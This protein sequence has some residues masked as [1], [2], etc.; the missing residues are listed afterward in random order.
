MSFLQIRNLH[1]D[2]G[3][4]RLKGVDLDLEK[5]KYLNIVGPTGAG[6]TILLECLVGFY[7]PDKGNILLEGEEITHKR[8][9][10]RNIGIVYQDYALM[11]HMD[12]YKN[13]AYG[14]HKKKIQDIPARVHEMAE[15]LSITHL[16]HRKPQTLS[17]GEQ[18]RVALARSLA[19]RPRLLLMDEPLSALDPTTKK[20]IRKMLRKVVFQVGTTVIHVTH[21]LDD[22]WTLADEAA[23]MREGLLEQKGT[24]TEV[25]ERPMTD[26]V[27]DFVGGTVLD[28]TLIK[29]E[30]GLSTVNVSG[31]ELKSYDQGETGENVRVIIRPENI[32]LAHSVPDKVSARNVLSCE[33]KEIEPENGL[34]IVRLISNGLE[35]QVLITNNGLHDLDLKKG[36]KV[37]AMIKCVHVRLA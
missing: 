8:P 16:L 1:K 3:E 18:Q 4:F 14:L 21:D 33:I 6:K 15:S 30:N 35:L 9:E 10:K 7:S 34:N 5:G 20:S 28:G 29:R 27:A 11:P 25:L 24:I 13:I 36:D 31:I 22:V 23:V 26:F 32:I 37:F 12:V 19:V 17:G 2:L